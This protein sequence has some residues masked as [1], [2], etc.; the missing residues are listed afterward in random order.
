MKIR[1]NIDDLKKSV[2]DMDLIMKG[3]SV[4]LLDC[5]YIKAEN[6]T[7]TIIA[8][9]LD[10]AAI[11]HIPG[12]II[13]DGSGLIQRENLGMVLKLKDVAELEI[14]GDICTVK[15]NRIF[16]FSALDK[17]EDF[18][19]PL[20]FLESNPVY[21]IAED[22]LLYCLKL[23]KL[24]PTEE[25]YS[26]FRGLWVDESNIIACDGYRLGKIETPNRADKKFMIPDFALHY[27]TKALVK[28]SAEPVNFYLTEKRYVKAQNANF[29]LIFR[30]YEGECID[31]SDLFNLE[32]AKMA[33]LYKGDIVNTI[34]FICD[35]YKLCYGNRRQRKP[36]KYSF[37]DNRLKVN[38][39]TSGKQVMEDI[40]IEG[41]DALVDFAIEFDPLLY[42]EILS[43][44]DGNMLNLCFE[45]PSTRSVIYGEKENEKYLILPMG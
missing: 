28:T 39:S 20:D 24:L 1:I 44:I 18:P 43:L 27:L 9:N 29:E 12:K 14:D 17:A 25:Q 19:L 37:G 33:A 10:M 41:T 16:K 26:K 22:Q 23:K 3:N 7:I 30:Q 38:F 2:T 34:G 21:S 8:N 32:N 5:L 40:P 15:A 11:K 31:Y 45:K 42:Y 35:V 36:M 4:S 13:A 6:D